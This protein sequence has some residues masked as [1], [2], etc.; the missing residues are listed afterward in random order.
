M[1]LKLLLY[2][3]VSFLLLSDLSAQAWLGHDVDFEYP[4]PAQ[5]V[6]CPNDS[7]AWTFGLEIDSLSGYPTEVNYTVSRTI[8]RGETWQRIT[9]PH[10]EPGYFSCLSALSTDVACIAYVDYAEGNK[11]LKTTDGGNTWSLLPLNVG[12]WINIGYFFD[13]H[14]G[15][16]IGD[17]DSLGFEIYTTLD[18]GASWTRVDPSQVPEAVPDEYGY[19]GYYEVV[20]TSIWFE[21]SAGRVYTSDDYGSTWNVFSGPLPEPYFSMAA[22]QAHHVYLSYTTSDNPDGSSPVTAFY[23]TADNGISWEDITPQDNG[24]WI[25][26][27][28]PVPGSN[29]VIGSFNAGFSTGLFETR[30]SYDAGASWTTTDN[31]AHVLALDFSDA[32]SGYAGRWKPL[33]DLSPTTVYRYSGSPLTGILHPEPLSIDLQIIPN[34]TTAYVDIR[35]DGKVSEDYWIL[36]N[37]LSGH[38]IVRYEYT[39]VSSI[40]Q[41]ID[42]KDLPAGTYVITMASAHGIRTE[43]IIRL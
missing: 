12:V 34:P 22:D 13:E 24:W 10:N 11:L 3:F 25:F 36:V 1:N 2:P 33:G 43:K 42:M 38:L 14:L 5:E 40:R 23:R 41:N 17:P 32:E 28:E 31:S 37:D 20:G 8:D 30:I 15:V 27:L 16:A 39:D 26:D 9:F 35:M 29:T 6:I 4:N 18:G 19:G 21:T 7:A